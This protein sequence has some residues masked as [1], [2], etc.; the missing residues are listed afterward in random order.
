MAAMASTP[1]F[2][3][4]ATAT[5]T[6]VGVANSKSQSGAVAIGGGNG[7]GGNSASNLT[8][9]NAAV[10]AATTTTV[11]NTG[12]ETVRT[13]PNAYS[14]GLAAAGLETCL[15]SVSGG[16][17][18]IGTGFSFGTTI[19]DPGCAARLD[20]RTLWSMGLKKAAV[21]RLC[22]MPE[23]YRSMPEVCALYMPQQP[24]YVASTASAYASAEAPENA[25]GPIEVIEGKTGKVRM[26]S[27]YD[28]VKQK[29]HHWV[30]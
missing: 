5:G 25:G 11:N 23:I 13:V 9:N 3:Q 30:R 18:W 14:P 15:G 7:V 10:P 27:D 22:L 20:A 16:G 17:S 29:C 2:A 6:G 26:C 28:A 1:V 19:P 12:T 24:A 4:T 21:I 8:V